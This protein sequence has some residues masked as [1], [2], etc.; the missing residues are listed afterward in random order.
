MRARRS[1]LP[2]KG[3]CVVARLPPRPGVL[4]QPKAIGVIDLNLIYV[5]IR[6]GELSRLG[7][8]ARDAANYRPNGDGAKPEP[9]GRL[10]VMICGA[11]CG[12]PI[13][14]L[15]I[16]ASNIVPLLRIMS[17]GP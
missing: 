6:N 15:P 12:I 3:S 2:N 11:D 16:G 9:N 5:S 7:N 17:L 14:V 13:G 4:I 10:G 1:P 8:H